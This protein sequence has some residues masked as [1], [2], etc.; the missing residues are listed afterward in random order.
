[1]LAEAGAWVERALVQ[2]LRRHWGGTVASLL[3]V[4][5]PAQ[6][7]LVASFQEQATLLAQRIPQGMAEP[8]ALAK[9]AV[10]GRHGPRFTT[11]F[12]VSPSTAGGSSTE[13]T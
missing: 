4:E 9:S 8:Q 6:R 1:M 5:V 11:D 12:V 10:L 3:R 7:E 2:A 13:A